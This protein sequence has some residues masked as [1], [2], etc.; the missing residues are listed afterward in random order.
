MNGKL[1]HPFPYQ[2]SK[3]NIAPKILKFFPEK[4]ERLIEP[5]AGSAAISIASAYYGL[6]KHFIINDLNKPLVDLLR[7]IVEHP[8]EIAK[9]YEKLWNEQLDNP[10][11]FFD[12][13]RGQFN[14]TG[15]PEYFLYLLARCVKGSVRYN[16]NGEFNQ[17]PDNRRKGM[18]PKKMREN[19]L[20][21]SLLLKGKTEFYSK[22]YR[23]ILKLA[24][25]RDLVYMDP[26]YQGVCRNRDTRYLASIQFCEFV[27]SLEELNNRNIK[28][29]VSYDGRT[30]EK[31]HGNKLPESLELTHIEIEAGVSSQATL[32]GKKA[33]TIESLYLSPAL[34]EEIST[35]KSLKPARQLVIGELF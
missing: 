30:G 11:K 17:S 12:Y 28:Y 15:K 8:I 22:N 2:G 25:P 34:S 4:I 5:F 20:G 13:I 10:R 19:I 1:P 16:G 18:R 24:T 27:E 33:V 7:M 23:D 29:I 31:V 21:V 26:P 32:L 14:L 35:I 3:R 9:L 6:S